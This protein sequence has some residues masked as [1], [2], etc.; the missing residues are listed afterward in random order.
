MSTATLDLINASRPLYIHNGPSGT[1]STSPPPDTSVQAHYY[2]PTDAKYLHR[3]AVVKPLKY[4]YP[5][6]HKL[7]RFNIGRRRSTT[8]MHIRYTTGTPFTHE[9]PYDCQYRM[10]Q[11][12]PTWTD[13]DRPVYPDSLSVFA[14]RVPVHTQF[15]H[16]ITAHPSSTPVLL[17]T[18]QRPFCRHATHQHTFTS[19]L[20][21]NTK[22]ILKSHAN[23]QTTR[24][25]Q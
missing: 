3:V 8:L 25:L 6:R 15:T 16:Y 13:T 12:G 10:T 14:S 18:S 21:T 23:F 17:R 11:S 5:T 1:P 4:G 19:Q 7:G 2:P 9:R 24:H 22:L 20:H